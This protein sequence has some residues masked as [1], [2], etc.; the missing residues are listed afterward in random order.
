MST[1]L[2]SIADAT[3]VESMSIEFSVKKHAR[4]MRG[5][6]RGMWQSEK[7]SKTA[8][9]KWKRIRKRGKKEEKE[10]HGDIF[11]KK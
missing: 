6:E 3:A 7:T 11:E 10:R 9:Y 5:S 2:F 8:R 4:S 1:V